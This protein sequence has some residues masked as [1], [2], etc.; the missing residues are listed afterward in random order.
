MLI[1]WITI[2]TFLRLNHIRGADIGS[3]EPEA[4]NVEVFVV[5]D[6]VELAA[7]LQADALGYSEVLIDAEIPIPHARPNRTVATEHVIGEAAA[8]MEQTSADRQS[9]ALQATRNLR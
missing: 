7:Q 9:T 6:V 8:L 2:S 3:A 1:E 5:E 4:Q